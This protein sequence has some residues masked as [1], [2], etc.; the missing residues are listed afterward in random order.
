MTVGEGALLLGALAVLW[1]GVPAGLAD[2]RWGYA[3]EV[4]GSGLFA[5]AGLAAL[6]LG[7]FSVGVGM[8]PIGEVET[9]RMD[10]LSGFFALTA[11]IVWAAISAYSLGYDRGSGRSLAVAYAVTLGSMAVVLGAS[12]WILFL[13]AWETMTLAAVAML[14]QS[15]GPRT[16][17]FSAAFVFLAFGEGS[18]LAIA[19]AVGALHAGRGNFEFGPLG[20]PGSLA[21]LVFVAA[22]IGFGVK[23]GIVPFQMGEWLPIARAPA[24][25]NAAA[26]LS[27][28]VTLAGAYG[29]L[30]VLSLLPPAPPLEWGALLL[31]LGAISAFLGAAFASVSESSK[32]LPA[33]SSVENS[34]LVLVALGVGLLAA[35]DGIAHLAAFCLFAVLLQLLVHALAKATLFLFSGETERRGRTVE[36]AGGPGGVRNSNRP[37]TLAAGIA[38]LSLAAAPPIAG[39]VSE[40]MILE[41]LFQSYLFPQP[42]VEFLGLVAGAAMALAAGLMVMAMVKILGFTALGRSAGSPRGDSALGQAAPLAGLAGVLLAMGLVAPTVLRLLAPAASV[43]GGSPLA[44]PVGGFPGLP[45]VASILS[46]TAGHPFGVVSPPALALAFGGAILPALTYF[47]LARHRHRR[48]VPA[49]SGGREPPGAGTA[50]LAFGYSAGMRHLLADLLRT[51]EFPRP[52]APAVPAVGARSAGVPEPTEESDLLHGVYRGLADSF[53]TVGRATKRIVMPGHTGR[54]LAYLL[55]VLFLV[56]VYVSIAFGPG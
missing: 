8:G 25:A 11:G 5:A 15:A 43:V 35:S 3:C 16:R 36:I 48:R 47:G 27:A 24:P 10:P 1:A 17:V 38:A 6:L 54:Y 18:S 2:R 4:T 30:R 41:A 28:T 55:V 33:Y 29:L 52:P 31:I 22:V 39:F 19:V 51:G 23:M 45:F 56:L 21:S 37:G 44:A 26:V 32:A 12:D 53:L 13:A 46:G 42:W 40:W 34:G 50:G 14:L 49:W 20:G 7:S 9:L